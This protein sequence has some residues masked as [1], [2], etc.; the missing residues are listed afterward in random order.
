MNAFGF[1]FD[2]APRPSR[3]SLGHHALRVCLIGAL[4][5]NT[6]GFRWQRDGDKTLAS[7]MDTKHQSIQDYPW[8][9]PLE[10]LVAGMPEIALQDSFSFTVSIN[11]RRIEVEGTSSE[12]AIEFLLP[13]Q[14]APFEVTDFHTAWPGWS[15]TGDVCCWTI[16][17]ELVAEYD[18]PI[19]WWHR[20]W[21][22]LDPRPDRKFIRPQTPRR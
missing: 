9:W 16:T 13:K 17:D 12:S 8:H 4:L 1:V 7:F 18:L 22:W 6:K 10:S 5:Q 2:L 14:Y 15:L 20:F 11:E 21:N 3:E 19:G